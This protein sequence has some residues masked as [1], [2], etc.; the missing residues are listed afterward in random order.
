MPISMKELDTTYRRIY[1]RLMTGIF[2][3][4]ATSL[5]LA[6]SLLIGSPKVAIWVSEAAQA[7]FVGANAP[8]VP[9]P[10]RLAGTA[11]RIRAIKAD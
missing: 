9:E 1:R 2:I 6:L 8:S 3:V 4:C 7:E 11:R 5:L 10:M